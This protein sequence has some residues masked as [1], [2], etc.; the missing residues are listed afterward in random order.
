MNK[1]DLE[2]NIS[3]IV[4]FG[5]PYFF[6]NNNGH[7]ILRI[8][9]K[10]FPDIGDELKHPDGGYLLAYSLLCTH[11]GCHLSKK[12]IPSIKVTAETLVCGPCGCHGSQFDLLKEGLVVDGPATLS[13]PKL[14]LVLSNDGQTIKANNYREV[15]GQDIATFKDENWPYSVICKEG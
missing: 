4:D 7:F 11:M 8:D 12:K 1:L 13:L 9:E 14:K 3:E 10:I 15:N 5:R 6:E 2:V